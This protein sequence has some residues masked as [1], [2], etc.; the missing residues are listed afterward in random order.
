L[1]QFN[2]G[3]WTRFLRVMSGSRPVLAVQGVTQILWGFL[4]LITSSY[5]RFTLWCVSGV[6]PVVSRE[7]V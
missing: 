3:Q 7:I 6:F 4:G 1:S 2:D 5:G